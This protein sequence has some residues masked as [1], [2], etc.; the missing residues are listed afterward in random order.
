MV[1]DTDIKV[2]FLVE[3]ALF[4]LSSTPDCAVVHLIDSQAPSLI[5]QWVQMDSKQA[6]SH[7]KVS[8]KACMHFAHGPIPK[9]TLKVIYT[10]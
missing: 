9:S 7:W 8:L 2:K 3:P 10:K 1:T 6:T 4:K 5:K